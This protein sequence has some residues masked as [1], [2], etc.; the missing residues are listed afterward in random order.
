MP[1]SETDE[2]DYYPS[3]WTEVV[4]D[5]TYIEWMYDDDESILVRLDGTRGDSNY[6]V[7]PITGVNT[8]DEEFVTRP[9]SSLTRQEAFDVAATLIYAING[10]VGRING[11]NEFNG[12]S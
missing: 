8:D 2:L 11:E 12:D 5:E 6:T 3:G 9:V 1:D 10:T 7:S 4:H